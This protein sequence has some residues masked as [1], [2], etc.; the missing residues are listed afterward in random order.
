MKDNQQLKESIDFIDENRRQISSLLTNSAAWFIFPS[1]KV[2]VLK[3][4]K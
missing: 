2:D 3:W 1:K 4:N